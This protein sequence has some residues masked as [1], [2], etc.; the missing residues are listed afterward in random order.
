MMAARQAERRAQNARNAAERNAA[1]RAAAARR[2]ANAAREAEAAQ[3]AAANN[4]A[5]REAERVAERARNAAKAAKEAANEAAEKA[6]AAGRAAREATANTRAAASAGNAA[7]RNTMAAAGGGSSSRPENWVNVSWSSP[8]WDKL[9][10]F[11][12]GLMFAA[13][14][15]YVL[16]A[17]AVEG[18]KEQRREAMMRQIER[19]IKEYNQRMEDE[20]KRQEWENYKR[21][22]EY[23]YNVATMEKF[24]EL[25]RKK[26]LPAEVRNSMLSLPRDHIFWLGIRSMASK[27]VDAGLLKSFRAERGFAPPSNKSTTGGFF[28]ALK[29]PFRLLQGEN[30]P[31]AG[32][33]INAAWRKQIDDI[34]RAQREA[35]EAHKK[36]QAREEAARRAAE[37]AALAELEAQRKRNAEA[38]RA[39]AEAA[40]KAAEAAEREAR[41]AAN[42]AA[43]VQALATRRALRLARNAAGRWKASARQSAMRRT[44]ENSRLPANIKKTIFEHLPTDPHMVALLNSAT[45]ATNGR[46]ALGNVHNYA[47]R[48]LFRKKFTPVLSELGSGRAKLKPLPYIPRMIAERRN[49]N[50]AYKLGLR[51]V[52]QKAFEANLERTTTRLAAEAKNR[53]AER[54]RKEQALQ[55]EIYN[56]KLKATK[57]YINSSL[58]SLERTRKNISKLVNS[59]TIK[60]VINNPTDELKALK[61]ELDNAE[62]E[63]TNSAEKLKNLVENPPANAYKD[64]Y[65]Y[66]GWNVQEAGRKL[67]ETRKRVINAH[68]KYYTELAKVAAQRG[69]PL[70]KQRWQGVVNKIKKQLKA[71]REAPKLSVFAMASPFGPRFGPPPKKGFVLNALQARKK[72]DA[73]T[74]ANRKEKAEQLAEWAATQYNIAQKTANENAKEAAKAA[75]EAQRMAAAAKALKSFKPELSNPTKKSGTEMFALEAANRAAKTAAK[76]N[77]SKQ[78]ATKAAAYA[79]KLANQA[80]LWSPQ[81]A[82]AEAVKRKVA[83]N[84]AA[85]NRNAAEKVAEERAKTRA[86][87]IIQ[88]AARA[89]MNM[90]K[91][92]ALKGKGKA[93]NANFLRWAREAANKNEALKRALQEA[94]NEE[95]ARALQEEERRATWKAE[96]QAALPARIQRVTA[97]NMSKSAVKRQTNANAAR[98]ATVNDRSKRVEEAKKE[99]LKRLGKKKAA[100]TPEIVAVAGAGSSRVLKSPVRGLA[101]RK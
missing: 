100:P 75:T 36:Q 70:S 13:F 9:M 27:S 82:R 37:A 61:K 72:L 98:R 97:A 88:R 44:I 19:E 39:A 8:E 66:V 3:R 45:A 24:E 43:R 71:A 92:R 101:P 6:A 22:Y 60:E 89:F 17:L 12:R 51:G 4:A 55:R 63:N 65:V 86:A 59:P 35:D 5:R 34:Q 41:Q 78:N 31:S 83:A 7:T 28:N 1:A 99:L 11:G 77:Q 76:A 49:T 14:V 38:A 25:V 67:V 23:A 93:T 85:A 68:A 15:P 32:A 53:E 91:G 2:A 73:R 18:H 69:A 30:L 58:D 62:T 46:N 29:G 52:T 64:P 47:A 50:R 95:I 40:R 56:K 81:K 94:K 79:K 20:A 84:K 90:R 80:A 48:T 16:L 33:E 54:E 87:K 74:Y 21:D 26:G 10:G 57:K 96:R 42:L